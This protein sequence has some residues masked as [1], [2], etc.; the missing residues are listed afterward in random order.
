MKRSVPVTGTCMRRLI[1][2]SC[3]SFGIRLNA[4]LKSASGHAQK[5]IVTSQ[6]DLE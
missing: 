2:H 3:D 4:R 6:T 5:A 1:W